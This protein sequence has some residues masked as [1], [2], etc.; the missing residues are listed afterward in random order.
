MKLSRREFFKISLGVFGGAAAGIASLRGLD[1]VSPLSYELG[2]IRKAEDVTDFFQMAKTGDLMLIY[3]VFFPPFMRGELDPYD[4]LNAICSKV[5]SD[6]EKS[7]KNPHRID[8][9]PA[10]AAT[11]SLHQTASFEEKERLTQ[12]ISDALKDDRKVIAEIVIQNL[13]T[14]SIPNQDTILSYRNGL[15]IWDSMS[16][17]I[18]RCKA[19]EQYISVLTFLCQYLLTS[20]QFV[21]TYRGDTTEIDNLL[22]KISDAERIPHLFYGKALIELFL[23]M[24]R[25]K[26]NDVYTVLPQPSEALMGWSKFPIKFRPILSHLALVEARSTYAAWSKATGKT[27]LALGYQTQKDAEDGL[28]KHLALANDYNFV[29]LLSP[30]VSGQMSVPEKEF[31]AFLRREYG[32][33]LSDVNFYNDE[34]ESES[35]IRFLSRSVPFSTY[36]DELIPYSAWKTGEKSSYSEFIKKMLV[37]TGAFT[38]GILTTT[39]LIELICRLVSR[40][41]LTKND[42]S[43]LR[44]NQDYISN[45]IVDTREKID[46]YISTKQERQSKDLGDFTIE[47]Q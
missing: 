28:K 10:V 15:P 31:E 8:V 26:I 33:L 37:F 40:D 2:K 3:S 7:K 43:E 6:K 16:E 29:P 36:S 30:Y 27:T 25:I 47:E 20:R 19:S 44:Q 35:T 17:L 18:E 1:S 45:V 13:I 38:T 46:K 41:E 14:S 42:L 21:K 12:V 22:N 4:T 32:Q 5:K 24:P 39:G 11:H 9:L 34:K 23:N